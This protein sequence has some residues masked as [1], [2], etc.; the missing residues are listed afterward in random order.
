MLVS[1]PVPDLPQLGGSVLDN[2]RGILGL[3][4]NLGGNPLLFRLGP[5][6]HGKDLGLAFGVPHDCLGHPG[7]VLQLPGGGVLQTSPRLR[8]CRDFHAQQVHELPENHDV[9]HPVEKG[10]HRANQFNDDRAFGD[11]LH[12]QV[13][14]VIGGFG[15]FAA[16]KPLV[17]GTQSHHAEGQMFER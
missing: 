13:N 5:I 11:V 16:D 3:P 12:Q 1:V 8:Q 6:L 15:M 17:F 10:L 2:L 4:D 14:F 9:V 7:H